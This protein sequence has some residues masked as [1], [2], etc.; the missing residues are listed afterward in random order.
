MQTLA[1]FGVPHHNLQCSIPRAA[2]NCRA[3]DDSAQDDNGSITQ[4]CIVHSTRHWKSPGPGQLG[5]STEFPNFNASQTWLCMA[6]HCTT[7]HRIT[8]HSIGVALH[9]TALAVYC[10]STVWQSTPMAWHSIAPQIY[11]IALHCMAN[12]W[13]YIVLHRTALHC[14][15]QHCMIQHHMSLVLHGMAQH[16]IADHWHCMAWHSI[17]G[18]RSRSGRSHG[19]TSAPSCRCTLAQRCPTHAGCGLHCPI[20]RTGR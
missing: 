17:R 16:C 12:L 3:Q 18:L 19:R 13:H 10:T 14:M 5:Q 7:K 2:G 4:H 6:Q 9:G 8:R 11:G 1:A 20:R 15:A